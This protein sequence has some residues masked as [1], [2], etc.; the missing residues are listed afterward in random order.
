MARTSGNSDNSHRAMGDLVNKVCIVF[1]S[2]RNS[3]RNA[4]LPGINFHESQLDGIKI[5]RIDE[6][7]FGKLKASIKTMASVTGAKEVVD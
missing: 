2:A 4:P 3:F 5:D 1:G 7:N 6:Y